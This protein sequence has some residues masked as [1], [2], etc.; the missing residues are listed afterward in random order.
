MIRFELLT[1]NNFDIH[2]LDAYERRQDVKRVYRRKGGE[3]VLVDMPYV[4]DWSLE[5]KRQ[6]APSRR[7]SCV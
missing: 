6:A 7:R 4:E 1:E 2:S 5:K 3:Y